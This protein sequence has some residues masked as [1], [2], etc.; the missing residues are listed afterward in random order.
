ML[1][2]DDR[3]FAEEISRKEIVNDM[4]M[5]MMHILEHLKEYTGST[6]TAYIT[7]KRLEH[8]AHLLLTTQQ[9]VEVICYVSGFSSIATF[10]RLFSKHYGCPPAEY[11]T[12][13]SVK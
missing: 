1:L 6:L 4:E 10:Y 3:L 11:R 12:S 2:T 5:P 7:N 8:A 13:H 9:K